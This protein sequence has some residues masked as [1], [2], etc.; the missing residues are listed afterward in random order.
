[1]L[2]LGFV[3]ES[4]TGYRATGKEPSIS[5]VEID[6]RKVERG[7]MFVAFKGE[8]ADG[9]NYVGE[10]FKAGAI[11]ALV[12]RPVDG[13]HMLIDSSQPFD[14]QVE[15]GSSLTIPLCVLVGSTLEAL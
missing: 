1:M 2:T 10:A 12:E 13:N 5:S 14:E 11:V 15:E 4:L 7:S 6:S 9:H 8:K 3:L